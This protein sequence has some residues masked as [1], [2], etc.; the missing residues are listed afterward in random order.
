MEN[1][2]QRASYGA[3]TPA[4]PLHY[5]CNPYSP[6]L[7]ASIATILAGLFFYIEKPSFMYN[8]RVIRIDE[9]DNAETEG[10]NDH[11]AV[12]VVRNVVRIKPKRFGFNFPKETFFTVTTSCIIVGFFTYTLFNAIMCSH[13]H[14][15]PTLQLPINQAI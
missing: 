10:A 11:D 9:Q 5:R 15:E 2:T 12:R 14:F 3:M 6:F 1:F 7:M 4:L 8:K 13:N